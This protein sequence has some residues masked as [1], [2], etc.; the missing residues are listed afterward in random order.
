MNADPQNS[1]TSPAPAPPRPRNPIVR[2]GI[3]IILVLVVALTPYSI[4]VAVHEPDPQETVILGQTKIASGSPTGLRILVRNRVS[5]KPIRGA[6]VELSL[7]DKTAR[8]VKLG[9][10]QTDSNG[11]L[12]DLINVPE[13]RPGKYLLIVDVTSALGRDQVVKQVEVQHPARLLL[14]SDKPIYQPGQTIH[15]RSLTVNGRT[16]KPFANEAVTFE[17]SDPKGNKVFKETRKSSGFG[18]ASADFVLASELNPGRYEIRALAGATSTERTIEIKRYILPKFKIQ[19]TTDKPCYLPGETVSGWVL[20]NY[21]FGKPVGDATVKLTAATFQEKPV[22]VG[23]QQG[24]TD[25]AGKY[26]FQ[27]VLPNFFVGMPQN[28]EQAFL[29][30]TAEVRDTAGHVEEK[31]LSLSV[32]QNELE[33][34]AIPEAGALIPASR[35]F[36]MS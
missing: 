12:A 5:G 2:S 24:R 34:T 11:S 13:I 1:S 16:E 25:A 35:M 9:T 15:I 21:F 32:A 4:Y 29:D 28:N 20:A 31:A 14:T 33:V 7:L 3:G 26:S 36:C 27:F 8:T 30:L 23:E 17:V 18:I 10:F 6:K 19:I 22:V